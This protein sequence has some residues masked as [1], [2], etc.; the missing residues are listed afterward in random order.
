MRQDHFFPLPALEHGRQGT[1][2][3]RLG[4][5]VQNFVTMTTQDCGDGLSHQRGHGLIASQNSAVQVQKADAVAD[6]VKG[7]LPLLGA[8]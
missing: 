2:G 4:G 3:N 8:G 6:G 7:G 5:T 1:F